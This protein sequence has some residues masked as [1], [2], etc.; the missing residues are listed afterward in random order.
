MHCTTLEQ[1]YLLAVV[2]MPFLPLPQI[3]PDSIT[4]I[5]YTKNSLRLVYVAPVIIIHS[6]HHPAG[7][8]TVVSPKS[9]LC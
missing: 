7:G 5:R 6:T 4:R 9:Y 3:V 8:E 2:T 1:E